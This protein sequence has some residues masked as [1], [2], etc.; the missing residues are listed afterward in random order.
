MAKPAKHATSKSAA[1]KP[2]A[3]VSRAK[4]GNAV[5]TKRSTAKTAQ[6]TTRGSKGIPKTA[7]AATEL[8]VTELKSTP[9]L[10]SRNRH[11]GHYDFAALIKAEPALKRFVSKNPHGQDT[12]P[13]ANPE[14]VK[15]L[16]KALLAQHYGIR[17]W[18]IPAGFL[19]PPIPGRA[20]Y[21]HR[22][23]ELLYQD[24]PSL[25]QQPVNMLDIGVG[26]NCI[27]PIIA[28]VEYGWR[29]VGSDIDPISVKNAQVI[30]RS[31]SPL[32]DKIHCRLQ[33]K[34]Q[35]IFNGIIGADERYTVTTCN[36][37]FHSSL[38]EAQQGTQRK[39][40][41]LQQN[42][43]KRGAKPSAQ[44]TNANKAALNFGGQ[45]AELWCPGGEAAFL[46]KMAFESAK[47]A[48][49]VLW[50]SSLISKKDNVRWMR[51]QLSKAGAVE[52]KIV[53][54]AQGQKISRFI[55]WSFLT[56]EQ[57]LQWPS[58]ANASQ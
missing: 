9:G 15:L 40:A 5:T 8:K 29:V 3:K 49:Q 38:A 58:Q 25:K 10:H 1:N 13:F 16:N 39:L 57:R 48:Q 52:A 51:K 24:C 35:F 33:T 41:N 56:H 43:Q 4:A 28:S 45:K 27:Y 23:A 42:Q 34:P 55:A 19:C 14:A 22:L 21:I 12:I 44:V 7:N 18:D 47:H 54:M 30:V 37:P 26:A 36:P 50:F 31:N 32:K 11:R 20:D 6:T 46:Q 2:L 17:Q 53:E